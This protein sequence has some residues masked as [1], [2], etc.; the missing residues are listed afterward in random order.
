MIIPIQI[1][2][3]SQWPFQPLQILYFLF[4]PLLLRLVR[5]QNA[6]EKFSIWH[7]RERVT[8]GSNNI[9]SVCFAGNFQT[10]DSYDTSVPFT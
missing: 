10:C 1:I 6:V 4:P 8:V 5:A 2:S 3:S 7:W 9:T